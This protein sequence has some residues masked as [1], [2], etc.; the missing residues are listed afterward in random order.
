MRE[1]ANTRTLLRFAYR[2]ETDRIGPISE[3]LKRFGGLQRQAAE[4]LKAAQPYSG[5]EGIMYT[6]WEHKFNDL[7]RF[8]EIVKASEK[9]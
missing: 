2:P 6:T 3:R 7:E 8:A 1:S 5:V 4:W 9:R